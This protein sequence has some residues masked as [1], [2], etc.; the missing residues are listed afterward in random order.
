MGQCDHCRH[1]VF[2]LH[3]QVLEAFHELE[4]DE[5][6]YT[7]WVSTDRTELLSINDTPEDFVDKLFDALQKP[8]CS[9]SSVQQ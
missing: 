4:Y 7:Q 5:V 8:L 2:T 3:Q 1:Q 6:I 9:Q